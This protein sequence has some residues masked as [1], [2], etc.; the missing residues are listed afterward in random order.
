MGSDTKGNGAA[1]NWLRDHVTY[2]GEGCLT[3]PFSRNPE[4][5]YGMFGYNGRSLYAHRFMC[6]LVHGPAPSRKHQAS[7]LCGLGHEGCVHPHHLAWKTNA[8][9]QLDRR[10]HGT[11][12]RDGMKMKLTHSQVAEARR[13]KGIET[14]TSLAKRFGV[15]PG[16]IEYWQRHNRAPAQPGKSISA[17]YRRLQRERRAAT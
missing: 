7:H 14:Q 9:N 5:G 4:K 11:V 12:R 6:E 10:T 2:A 13:L 15:R 3:W 1:V 8:E 16:C 17:M